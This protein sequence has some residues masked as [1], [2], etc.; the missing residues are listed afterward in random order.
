MK[1]NT[2][3]VFNNVVACGHEDRKFLLFLILICVMGIW[4]LNYLFS[5]ESGGSC[6]AM[7]VEHKTRLPKLEG[8]T[9]QI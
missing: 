5:S 3:H 4:R 6:E 1:P 8:G 9:T 2:K 7:K